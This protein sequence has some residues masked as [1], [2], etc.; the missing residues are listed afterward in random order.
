L[1]KNKICTWW[2]PPTSKSKDQCQAVEN[3]WNF[4]KVLISILFKKSHKLIR[5]RLIS[6]K[7]WTKNRIV[8]IKGNSRE[9]IICLA[10][11]RWNAKWSSIE[12][13]FHLS[14]WQ[15]FKGLIM[16]DVGSGM[17]SKCQ[18]SA[19]YALWTKSSLLLDFILPTS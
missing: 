17:G 6:N 8:F 10:F 1:I 15:R 14:N 19:K 9:K 11:K 13:Q 18:R 12:I 3:I 16:S 5:K 7:Q 2:K 4:V